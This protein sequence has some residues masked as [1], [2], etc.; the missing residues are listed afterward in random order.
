MHPYARSLA[1]GMR[2]RTSAK[3]RSLGLELL[4]S[5]ILSVSWSSLAVG[6]CTRWSC[7]MRCQRPDCLAARLRPG[8]LCSA[9][10]LHEPPSQSADTPRSATCSQ[11]RRKM[12]D[13]TPGALKSSVGDTLGSH[14]SDKIPV[15][16]TFTA[17]RS[18]RRGVSDPCWS[19]DAL[20]ATACHLVVLREPKDVL[21]HVPLTRH[22]AK[23]SCA[24]KVRATE[25]LPLGD[26]LA[27]SR[28]SIVVTTK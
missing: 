24:I 6:G 3:H 23:Q 17:P 15:P 13:R 19:H 25:P 21:E 5:S 7:W 12:D 18:S 28:H 1:T 26:T 11:S 20:E 22:L 14:A 8:N 9:R 10:N 16:Q 4:Q 2:Q 27:S